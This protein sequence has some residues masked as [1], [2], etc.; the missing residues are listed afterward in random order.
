MKV[1]LLDCGS[2]SPRRLTFSVGDSTFGQI[3]GRQLDANFVTWND[4][5]EVL[6][7]PSCDVSHHFRT[8]FK[9]HPKTGVGEGLRYGALNLKC[10]FF[11]SQKSILDLVKLANS[12][13]LASCEYQII[14]PW[15]NTTIR[16]DEIFAFVVRHN[17]SD[18]QRLS[19]LQRRIRAKLN[20]K[21]STS[22]TRYR[23]KQS[24]H[25]KINVC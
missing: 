8:G 7:H 13:P 19:K 9:L 4:S 24:Q 23:S 18:W 22:R 15:T 14:V 10:F 11:L 16:G 21:D 3:I 5:N 2:F 25:S 12:Q 6:S 17:G 20:A 1:Q